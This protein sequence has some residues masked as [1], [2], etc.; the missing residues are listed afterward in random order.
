MLM[1]YWLPLFYCT[2]SL[3]LCA[4]LNVL[5]Y[6]SVKRW[7]HFLVSPSVRECLGLPM[8]SAHRM[9]DRHYTRNPLSLFEPHIWNHNTHHVPCSEPHKSIMITVCCDVTPRT[10]VDMHRRFVAASYFNFRVDKFSQQP[11]NFSNVYFSCKVIP[12][13][14]YLGHEGSRR[15]TLEGFSDTR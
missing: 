12:I 3:T 2:T 14:H 8:S 1:C 15:L 7:L 5:F 6:Q 10:P 13:H 9:C 11:P 4:S